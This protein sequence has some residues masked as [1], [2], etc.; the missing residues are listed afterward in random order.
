M[1]KLINLLDI[2]AKKYTGIECFDLNKEE[3]RQ[4]LKIILNVE[5]N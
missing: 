1:E 3:D 4:R 5:H 2:L